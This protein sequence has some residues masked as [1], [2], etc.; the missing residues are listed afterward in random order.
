MLRRNWKRGI[1]DAQC[2]VFERIEH[3]CR[4]LVRREFLGGRREL[5][6]SAVRSEVAAQNCDRL[7]RIDRPIEGPD[8]FVIRVA[9]PPRHDLCKALAAYGRC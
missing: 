2:K 4:A 6:G 7:G 5:D 3:Q 1:I 9:W 8:H